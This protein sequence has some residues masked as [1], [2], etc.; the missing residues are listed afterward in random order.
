MKISLE[1]FGS[2]PGKSK[3]NWRFAPGDNFGHLYDERVSY[4]GV[5]YAGAC[6][7]IKKDS[8]MKHYP[9]VYLLPDNYE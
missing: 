2:N 7:C 4:L 9:V 1:L 8:A 6:R 3:G 5:T